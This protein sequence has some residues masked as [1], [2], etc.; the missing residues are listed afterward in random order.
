MFLRVTL[1]NNLGWKPEGGRFALPF[2]FAGMVILNKRVVGVKESSLDRFVARAR[3]AV[4]LRGS[5][6]VLIT[7]SREMRTLNGRFRGKHKATDVLSF[8]PQFQSPR[9]AGDIAISAE[10]ASENARRLGHSPAVEVKIL[11]LHGVLHLAGFDHESDNGEMGS[12]E[13]QVREK[14]GLPSALIHRARHAAQ[15]RKPG[16]SRA[17]ARKRPAQ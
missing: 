13:E 15:V 10:I 14:L 12:L 2:S 11:A 4:G 5:V 7:S 17:P 8:P 6:T 1:E 9:F 16:S 3:R